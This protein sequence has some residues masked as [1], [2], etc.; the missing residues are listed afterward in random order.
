MSYTRL[1]KIWREGMTRKYGK[2]TKGDLL[3][4]IS[5]LLEE[6]NELKFDFKDL[7]SSSEAAWK[8]ISIKETRLKNRLREEKLKNILLLRNK[9]DKWGLNLTDIIAEKIL[10]CIRRNIC[11]EN[12]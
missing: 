12:N 7:R 8:D 3:W 5:F 9:T 4:E 6:L 2:M 11:D 1:K 10:T